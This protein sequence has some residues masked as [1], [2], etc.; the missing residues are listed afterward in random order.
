VHNPPAFLVTGKNI[1]NPPRAI[2]RRD[3]LGGATRSRGETL[4]SGRRQFLKS[5]AAFSV[6]AASPAICH[7]AWAA[8]SDVIRVGLIGCGLRG[9]AAAIN[10]LDADRGARLVAMADVFADKAQAARAAIKAKH[11]E[12]GARSRCAGVRPAGDAGR[13]GTRRGMGGDG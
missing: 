6:A 3:F 13:D 12:R 7:G 2:S 1:M 8:G 5:A 9:T 10:A 11:P 4:S